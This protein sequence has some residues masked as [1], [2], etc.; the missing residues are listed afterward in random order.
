MGRTPH[1][2]KPKSCDCAA[3]L[4]AENLLYNS[5]TTINTTLLYSSTVPILMELLRGGT[6]ISRL[7]AMRSRHGCAERM[8]DPRKTK[9]KQGQVADTQAMIAPYYVRWH[10]NEHFPRRGASPIKSESCKRW[11]RILPFFITC[12]S[13]HRSCFLDTRGQLDYCSGREREEFGGPAVLFSAWH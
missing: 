9:N 10:P 6:N 4:Y 1:T 12:S 3:V 2:Q 8:K 11:I 5:S 7:C 13:T